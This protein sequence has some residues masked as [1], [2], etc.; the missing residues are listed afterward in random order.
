MRW[1]QYWT[2]PHENN[3][4]VQPRSFLQLS[5]RV[6]WSFLYRYVYIHIDGRTDFLGNAPSKSPP[7]FL[8]PS[9]PYP[10]YRHESF[11]AHIQEREAVTQSSRERFFSVPPTELASS[12]AKQGQ[13]G[14]VAEVF[15]KGGGWKGESYLLTQQA[16]RVGEVQEAELLSTVFGKDFMQHLLVLKTL[17]SF[18]SLAEHFLWPAS[19][20][21]LGKYGKGELNWVLIKPFKLY[22]IFLLQVR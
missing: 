15:S 13:L 19:H 3:I 6:Q 20:T 17:V 8:Q 14:R 12:Y 10:L 4:C 21:F 11:T 9:F 7:T 18:M 2:I 22:F 16:T 5:Y 1:L